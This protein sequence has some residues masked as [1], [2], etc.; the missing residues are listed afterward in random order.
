MSSVPNPEDILAETRILRHIS[1]FDNALTSKQAMSL[2]SIAPSLMRREQPLRRLRLR[3]SSNGAIAAG[4]PVE[5]RLRDLRPD[6]NP[7]ALLP[8]PISRSLF[9]D[10]TLMARVFEFPQNFPRRGRNLT[11]RSIAWSGYTMLRGADLRRVRE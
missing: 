6:A 10:P 2:E 8:S 5:H 3:G 4:F 9:T 11:L 1:D 7:L